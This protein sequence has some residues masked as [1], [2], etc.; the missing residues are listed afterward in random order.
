MAQVI[1]MF[2]NSCSKVIGA[3]Y[4]HLDG[5]VDPKDMASPRDSEGHGT[6]T[7]STAA[8]GLV[9][10]ASVNGLGLGLARGGVPSARIAVYK[11]L[12]NDVAMDHDILAAFEAAI[13]DGVDIISI[14]IGSHYAKDYFTDSIA[15]GAFHAMKNGILTSHSAGNDGPKPQTIYSV[16][17]WVISVAASTIDRRFITMVQLGNNI[18]I[19]VSIFSLSHRRYQY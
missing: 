15:I 16:A 11:V 10:Q 5:E 6:H 12:W 1:L 14:S 18:L 13:A 17:P 4:F 2:V 19:P 9:E 7:A 3:Q 8:G